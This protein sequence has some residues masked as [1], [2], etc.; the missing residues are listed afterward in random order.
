MSGY[1]DNSVAAD[2]LR[3]LIERIENIEEQI[4]E[5]QE[6]R[7]DVYLELK[8]KG[9]DAKIVRQIVKFRKMDPA[10]LIEHHQ[11]LGVYA[12]AIGLDLL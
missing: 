6:D 10:K 8:A 3:L 5:V 1:G 7:K 2:D 9:Y 11:V 4:A 12:S